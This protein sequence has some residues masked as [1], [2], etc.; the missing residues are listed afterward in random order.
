MNVD[1]TLFLHSFFQDENLMSFIKGGLKI[2]N[3]YGIYRYLFLYHV[4]KK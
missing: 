1:T 2:K 3:A 4:G